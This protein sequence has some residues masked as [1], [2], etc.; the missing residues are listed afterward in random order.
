MQDDGSYAGFDAE[1]F[2]SASGGK[3]AAVR[4]IKVSGQDTLQTPCP[5]QD[6]V[7]PFYTRFVCMG[8][9]VAKH[10]SVKTHLLACRPSTV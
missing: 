7:P 2:T 9:H 6:M 4:H 5:A 8:L 1:E 10:E 3:A